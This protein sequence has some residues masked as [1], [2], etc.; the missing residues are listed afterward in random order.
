MSRS[1]PSKRLLVEQLEDRLTPAFGTPWFDGSSLTLSFTPDGTD[2][3]GT[4]SNLFSLMGST[5]AQPQWQR[6][7]LR[8]YQTWVAQANLNV[9]LVADGGQAMGTAGAPQEDIRF[10]DIRIGARSLSAP[11]TPGATVADAVGFDY[12]AKTW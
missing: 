1:L 10:G 3:S 7:I 6:E 11:G 12:D 4:P 2:I 5:T 9:G 8:A